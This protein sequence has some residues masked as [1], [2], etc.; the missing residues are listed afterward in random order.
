MD[1]LDVKEV[2]STSSESFS[3]SSENDESPIKQRKVDEQNTVTFDDNV[4]KQQKKKLQ[5]TKRE[6]RAEHAA[7]HERDRMCMVLPDAVQDRERERNFVHLATKGVVQLFNAVAERQKKLKDVSAATLTSKKRRLCGI[8]TESFNR[9]LE[10]KT[11]MDE[12]HDTKKDWLS[13]GQMAIK[14]E[15]EDDLDTSGIK[16]EPETDSE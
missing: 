9:R 16:T 2:C 4:G 15:T 12:T 11:N 5:R 14:S 6:L 3:S 10:S 13:D 8:S 7:K 1:Q